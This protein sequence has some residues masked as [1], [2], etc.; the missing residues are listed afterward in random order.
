[1]TQ[2]PHIA[3]GPRQ[4]GIQ[5]EGSGPDHARAGDRDTVV[6]HTRRVVERLPL[7]DCYSSTTAPDPGQP[8]GGSSR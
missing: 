2:R 3:L 6:V 5:H 4:A 8:V 7:A 1:M